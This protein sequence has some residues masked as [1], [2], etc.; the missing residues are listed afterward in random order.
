MQTDTKTPNIFGPTVLGIVAS[1][2]AVKDTTRKTL[3]IQIRQPSWRVRAPKNFRRGR[4]EGDHGTKEILGVVG[5]EVRPVLN[6]A[7]QLSTTR[8]NMQ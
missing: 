4:C 8:N 3:Q 7:Q 5:S 2:L 6:F 1:V